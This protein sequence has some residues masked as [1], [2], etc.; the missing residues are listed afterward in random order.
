MTEQD[1]CT[2]CGSPLPPTV[3]GGLC[4]ACLL[5]CGLQTNT[6]GYTD[7]TQTSE[8]WTPPT[9]EQL[10]PLFPEL[11]ILELIGRG[12][13]GAV[14][15]AREKQLDRLVALKILP[16]EIGREE[17][18]AKRFA[19]EAQ[20][21][22]KLN[23][24]NIVTIY[25]FGQRGSTEFAVGCDLYFFIM[26]YVDGLSL[27]QVLDS[28]TVS[29][30][31]ALAI[32][33]QIC[34]ALQYAHDRGIVHRDIKPENILL[35]RSGQVKIADFGL[36]KLVGLTVMPGAA[37][38][39]AEVEGAFDVTQINAKVMGTP[40]Y[41]SPEQIERPGEV[42]HRADIYSLGVVFYQMLTGELPKSRFEPPSCKVE[43]DVRLDEVVLR[44]LEKEPSRR[45]QQ[46]SE[47]R[48]QVA[49]I[50]GTMSATAPETQQYMKWIS[51]RWV[52]VR[53]WHRS[54]S[55]VGVR[56]GKRVVN[57][58]AVMRWFAVAALMM[59]VGV[60]LMHTTSHSVTGRVG[61]GMISIGLGM[62][63]GAV[64]GMVS[65]NMWALE[66]LVPLDTAPG[67][68][69]P[70][71]GWFRRWILWPM[72]A[73]IVALLVRQYVLGVY[74][75]ANDAVAPEIP[76]GSRVFVY[77]LVRTFGPGD[78]IIYHRDGRNML[79]RVVKDGPKNGQVMVERRGQ[80]PQA[81]LVDD[82]IGK[83]VF[84][85]RSSSK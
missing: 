24:P 28:S 16:P 53:P 60:L 62:L 37:A 74:R 6:A 30:E 42:D 26:E 19:R 64:I 7:D 33:P 12:G 77:K 72:V 49:T 46:V 35:N 79:G 38:A 50:A 70:K 23:H 76:V 27:R 63:L 8:R 61:V 4:P 5:K 71:W 45:Y 22:A 36:A 52:P 66:R 56:G 21:M 69:L 48:T 67:S 84:H 25:N 55:V 17:T 73:V 3:R 14:Y 65:L 34:D 20:A 83:V 68:E 41:M 40:Q 18:F 44:A 10:A 29:P 81:I 78:I 31:E 13:M 59:L 15:K 75:A 11:D 85:T 58:P 43:V 2:R 82:V 51:N 39:K 54:V 1:K 9:I 32:V 47:V 80:A 57:W